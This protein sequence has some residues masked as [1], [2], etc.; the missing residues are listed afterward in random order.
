MK[1]QLATKE[2]THD[3]NHFML[4]VAECKFK[5]SSMQLEMKQNV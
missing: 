4:G 2:T 1:N 5:W 3:N